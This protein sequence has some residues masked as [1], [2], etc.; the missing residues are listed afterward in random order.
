ML[1]RN[2]E[3]KASPINEGGPDIAGAFHFGC[4]LAE[5]EG[6]RK[7]KRKPLQTLV[8][9][10]S[11]QRVRSLESLSQSQSQAHAARAE[12]V[13]KKQASASTTTAAAAAAN[14][15]VAAAGED[16]QQE[17]DYIT[18]ADAQF[19]TELDDDAAPGVAVRLNAC[20]AQLIFLQFLFFALL[21]A[22]FCGSVGEFGILP[23][24]LY[25]F[26]FLLPFEV[27]WESAG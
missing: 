27:A 22:F 24:F 14:A 15:A 25:S 17:H 16:S 26:F 20:T 21:P 5:P 3:A 6:T 13:A 1:G 8:S 2:G 19:K 4:N 10:F 18:P 9:S 23:K 7:R 12:P 11:Q